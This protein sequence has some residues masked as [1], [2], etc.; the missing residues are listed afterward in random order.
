MHSINNQLSFDG[1][2]N[3][4]LKRID[5]LIIAIF[6]AYFLV[7]FI[8]PMKSSLIIGPHYVYFCILNTLVG[9]L[10]FYSKFESKILNNIPTKLYLFFIGISCL[11]LIVARNVTEGI[12]TLV[13]LF[14]IL[15]TFLNFSILLHN[16]LYLFNRLAIIISLNVFFQ[17]YMVLDKSILQL[18]GPS[19]ISFL[20]GMKGYSGNI[21]ILSASFNVKL[22]FILYGIAIFKG[23]KK[24][25]FITALGA[26][27]VTI[28]LLNA[29]AALLGLSFEIIIFIIG[30]IF[31]IYKEKKY[32]YNVIYAIIPIIIALNISNYILSKTK[33]EGR[34]E[35]VG[36]RLTKLPLIQ[37]NTDT[38]TQLRLTYWANALHVTKQHPFIGIGI[39][40]WKIESIPYEKEIGNNTTVSYNVHNDFLQIMAE[41]GFINGLIYIAIFA[42]VFFTDAR[43]ILSK[44]NTSLHSKAISLITILSLT[45]YV[46]DATFNF[47]MYRPT[48]Q[49]SF[50]LFLALSIVNRFSYTYKNNLTVKEI[51]YFKKITVLVI[52]LSII[53][54]Y[55]SYIAFQTY[56]WLCYVEYDINKKERSMKAIDLDKTQPVFPNIDANGIAIDQLVARYYLKEDKYEEAGVKLKA[57]K[58]IN[59]YLGD[60]DWYYATVVFTKNQADSTYYYFKEAFNRRPRNERYFDKAMFFAGLNKDT[61]EI[62]KMHNQHPQSLKNW[63]ITSRSLNQANYNLDKTIQL[64]DEGLEQFPKDSTLLADK[65]SL[66]IKKI[67]T[68]KV[69]YIIEADKY[70]SVKDFAKALPLF[71]LAEKEDQNDFKVKLN[72]GICYFYLSNFKNAIPYLNIVYASNTVTG[73][74]V[75]F[76]LG[77]SYA[78]LGNNLQSCKYLK[79]SKDKKYPKAIEVFPKICK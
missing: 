11:S 15:F 27:A 14:I 41:T 76:L 16:R 31:L 69:K 64:V 32:I 67:L 33:K 70:Y 75:E 50:A 74:I 57:A 12:L 78:G 28:F 1:I 3:P 73:G 48:M 54:L 42:F 13:Y 18:S 39:G 20:N 52:F 36:S 17:A 62:L 4:K 66:L 72:I 53:T 23:W 34:F 63:Q 79:I 30:Y 24:V 44:K 22:P 19:L 51:P 60:P 68:R 9:I 43:N 71:K 6:S 26:A 5:F 37:A 61:L 25:F 56:K 46:I 47:P 40:S 10:I 45:G 29:R 21:N 38:S 2:P 49:L 7:D 77:I 55:C 35:S 8:P 65:N 59:P 58:K